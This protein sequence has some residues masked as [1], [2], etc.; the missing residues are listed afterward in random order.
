MAQLERHEAFGFHVERQA[1]IFFRHGNPEQAEILH[2]VHNGL[3]HGIIVADFGLD[4]YA[5]LGHE[6]AHLFDQ[7]SADFGIEGHMEAP[8]YVCRQDDMPLG[9]ACRRVTVRY[10]SQKGGT[11][12]KW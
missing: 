2:L 8:I 11:S 1:A 12:R 10:Q 9:H 5:F 6:A 3:R 7:C 4:R